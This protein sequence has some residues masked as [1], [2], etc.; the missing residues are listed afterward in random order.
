MEAV[1]QLRSFCNRQNSKKLVS[2]KI[3]V[4]RNHFTLIKVSETSH[5]NLYVVHLVTNERLCLGYGFDTFDVVSGIYFAFELKCTDFR[6]KLMFLLTFCFVNLGFFNETMF[7]K[8]Y[9]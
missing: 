3:S 2:Q 7:D 9:I 8:R 5:V 4:M 6:M 1:L